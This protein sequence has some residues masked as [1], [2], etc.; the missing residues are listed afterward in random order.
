VC[1]SETLRYGYTTLLNRVYFLKQ[2]AGESESGISHSRTV[3]PFTFLNPGVALVP[4]SLDGAGS[5]GPHPLSFLFSP[6]FLFA[7]N[8]FLRD[9]SRCVSAP[10]RV[11][12]WI[13]LSLA[14]ST[15]SGQRQ[16]GEFSR[17]PSLLD[18][19]SFARE[20]HIDP[21]CATSFQGFQY[22]A[23]ALSVFFQEQR[24]PSFPF[25]SDFSWISNS[26]LRSPT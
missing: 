9:L 6:F 25:L 17:F 14:A 4:F 2:T 8:Q 15:D 22:G 1:C 24:S 16:F 21:T 18:S 20:L 12:P 3:P 11:D 26:E 23:N 7:R 10:E 5:W 19:P 13:S